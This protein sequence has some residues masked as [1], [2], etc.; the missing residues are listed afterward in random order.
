MFSRKSLLFLA[1]A[2]ALALSSAYAQKPAVT[3]IDPPNWWTGM[4][5]DS[6]RLLLYGDNLTGAAASSSSRGIAVRRTLPGASTHHLF[7]DIAIA[8]SARPQTATLVLRRGKDTTHV[9]FPLLARDMSEHRFQGFGTADVIYL[10]TPDRFADGD[11]TNDSVPGMLESAH[12]DEPFGRHGGDIQGIINH[13]DY[14][15]DLGVTTLWINPLVENNNPAQS[16]HGY[17]ATDFYRIDPRFGSNA[18]YRELVRTAHARGLKVILD[19]VANHI[20]INHPWMKDLPTRTWINGSIAHH[21]YARHVK[22]ALI[23]PHF[24]SATVRNL[25]E[26][27]FTGDMPDLNQRDPSLAAYII[28]NTIWWIE[29][30]GLDGIREDTYPYVEPTFWPKWCGAI[31]HEYPR[32]N[33]FGEV[34]IGDPDFIAPFQKGSTLAPRVHPAVPGVTDFALYDQINRVFGNGEST[35][36]LFQCLSKDYLY[37][38]RRDLV[39]FVDNHDVKRVLAVMNGDTAKVRLA[40]TFLLTTRGIPEIYYGTE[41][42]IYGGNNDGT[43]RADFPG[44][45]PNDIIDCFTRSGRTDAQEALYRF[46]QRLITLR[47][48]VPAIARGTLEQFPPVDNVYCY[49]R[50]YG[51]ET[52]LVVLNPDS[53]EKTV[54]L[55]VIMGTAHPPRI[56]RDMMEGKEIPPTTTI[57]VSPESGRILLLSSPLR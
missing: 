33:I 13:L 38:N 8:P 27:W 11:T 12:R 42:G 41:I 52:V 5:L 47:K 1:A 23:D 17:A 50:R 10:I 24:D 6:L 55:S 19:H 51:Q 2:C 3:R 45:F 30:T 29:S 22:S 32:I 36:L 34:W 21:D 49:V 16:Y 7:V 43:V 26:G 53:K 18:L 37:T 48:T 40:L 25:L 31:L 28:Q 14:L 20:S 44:G 4:K 56:R 46:V 54:D 39:T 9:D 57:Q 35:A 15:V